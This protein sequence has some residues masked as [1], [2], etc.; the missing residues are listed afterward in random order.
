MHFF[1]WAAN[2]ELGNCTI[3]PVF[4]RPRLF[5]VL[6][7]DHNHLLM[8]HH[9]LSRAA[10]PGAQAQSETMTETQRQEMRSG[11]WTLFPEHSD[12]GRVLPAPL[13]CR[14]PTWG[15]VTADEEL[16]QLLK[17]AHLSFFEVSQSIY[18]WPLKTSVVAEF[19]F[20]CNA[21]LF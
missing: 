19:I 11:K 2:I 21:T 16:L 6:V 18:C 5:H 1:S 20:G 17:G 10:A 3:H 4:I 7:T 12:I 14:E 8:I 9:L 13:L 15:R